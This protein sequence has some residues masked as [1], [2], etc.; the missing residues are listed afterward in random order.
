MTV[1]DDWTPYLSFT[2]VGAPVPQGSKRVG[3]AGGTGRPVLIDDNGPRLRPWRALITA[4]ARDELG[5]RGPDPYR[6][7]PTDPYRGPVAVR[8]LFVMPAPTRPTR[9]WPSVRPDLDKLV[10]AAL[11]ALTAAAVWADDSQVVSLHAA[12]QYPAPGA[13]PGLIATIYRRA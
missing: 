8:L 3:R 1:A 4:R 12:K 5:R 10:R 13:R 9:P 2:V 6:P 7:T 11:D